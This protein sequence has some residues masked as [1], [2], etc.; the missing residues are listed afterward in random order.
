MCNKDLVILLDMC[1]IYLKK[2]LYLYAIIPYFSTSFLSM[3]SKKHLYHVI[4]KKQHK[5]EEEIKD[6]KI[7]LFNEKKKLTEKKLLACVNEF[8]QKLS[9]FLIMSLS[10]RRLSIYNF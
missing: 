3:I 9:L 4:K 8:M 6:P 2:V 7:T 5:Q 1:V 10:A